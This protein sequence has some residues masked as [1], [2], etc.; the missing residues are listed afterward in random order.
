ML[1]EL[2]LEGYGTGE[3]IREY[4]LEVDEGYPYEFY[5]VYRQFKPSTSYQSVR[6]YFYI[7]EEIGLIE[8]ARWEESRAPIRRHLYKIRGDP[9]DP[10]WIRPQVEL[11]PQ[12]ALG[13]RFKE[14]KEEGRAYEIPTGRTRK[15]RK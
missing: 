3:A 7:L 13:R 6:R 1:E 11:Y 4:L 12:S 5:K 8:S 10:R 2:F 9:E 15:Y 14:L